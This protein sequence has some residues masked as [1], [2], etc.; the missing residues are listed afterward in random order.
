MRIIR[1]FARRLVSEWTRHGY[2]NPRLRGP[3]NGAIWEDHRDLQVVTAQAR[4][5][6]ALTD[7][8]QNGH[9]SESRKN[10]P[11]DSDTRVIQLHG[12]L[13]V[14]YDVSASIW[15]CHLEA[16]LKLLAVKDL[17]LA[18]LDNAVLVVR[19][20]LTSIARVKVS[21]GPRQR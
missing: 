19:H 20:L 15:S 4:F 8:F 1:G 3:M 7:G 12:S 16:S 17:I 5:N 6:T 2:S 11:G 21:C 13:E 14:G 10:M 18:V 9:R